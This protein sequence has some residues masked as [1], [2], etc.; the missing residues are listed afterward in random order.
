MY[1]VM[2]VMRCADQVVEVEDTITSKLDIINRYRIY[3]MDKYTSFYLVILDAKIAAIIP[4]YDV[5]TN[6]P[7]FRVM[8]ENLVQISVSSE[9]LVSYLSAYL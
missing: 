4:N 5:V 7:P 6:T 9:G 1:S 2:C 8:V 3:M